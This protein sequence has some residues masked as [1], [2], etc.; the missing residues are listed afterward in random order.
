MKNFADFNSATESVVNGWRKMRVTGEKPA[1]FFFSFFH[2]V[3]SFSALGIGV[4]FCG[5]PGIMVPFV[6]L[7]HMAY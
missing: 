4:L 7:L 2:Y 6:P 1:L 5:M 3:Y